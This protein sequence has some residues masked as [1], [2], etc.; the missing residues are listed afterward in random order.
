M[1]TPAPSSEPA[2]SQLISPPARTLWVMDYETIKNCFVAVFED[3]D[4]DR[5]EVFVVHRFRNDWKRFLDF[6]EACVKRKDYHLGYNNIAFDG[7]ITEHLL[8]NLKLMR[9][10][11]RAEEAA[12]F[13]SAYGSSVISRSN[14]GEFLDYPERRFKIPVIDI[15][16]LNHWDNQAKRSSLKWI[17]YA[18]DWESVEEMP[19]PYWEPVENR[20]TLDE[21]IGYCVNDV[22]ST[23]AI[24]N[25]RDRKG[26]QVMRGQIKLR[27]ALSREYGLNLHSASETRISKEIFLHYLSEKT[28]EDKRELNAVKT[29]RE[30]V[31]VKDIILPYVHFETPEFRSVLNWFSGLVVDTSD[32]DLE[33]DERKGPKFSVTFQNV[34]TDY[35]LGGL[36][37]CTRKGI[38]RSERGRIIKSADVTSFYPMLAIKNRWAPSHLPLDDFLDVYQG[39]FDK[40]KTYPKGHY[41]NYLFKIVLNATYGLSKNRYS[42]LYDPEFTFRITVNGQLLLSMLYEMLATRIPGAEP[43]M[44]NTD[45]LEFM[46]DADQEDLFHAICAEWEERTRL[47]LEYVTYERMII[48]DV[49]NYIA[50]WNE[51]GKQ[52]TKC[53]GRFE[54]EDLPLHKNKSFLVVPKALYAYFVDGVPPETYLAANQCFFDYCAGAKLRGDWFFE[55]R[56]LEED[57]VVSL[58]H[59]KLLRYYNSSKGGKLFKCNPDGREMM[60]EA[61]DTRQVIA[62]RFQ[63]RP[64]AEYNID[65]AYYLAAIRKEIKAI[66]SAPLPRYSKT[67]DV[68]QLSFAF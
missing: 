40:R 39:F 36:H 56:L 26:D 1:T 25:Y 13:L 62:N 5:R 44:Q 55:E 68:A 12:E 45:G 28:G 24:F 49:N 42:F 58:R 18:M 54:F 3:L 27:A 15:F 67:K 43:L 17:Q 51:G 20:R 34:K 29:L 16:K 14:R 38:Y 47:S 65:K 63:A 35:G 2:R 60:L 22:R 37:G 23:K 41:L 46:I 33:K 64:F 21:V 57:K 48:A 52:K 11:T 4:S 8:A 6:L 19:H 61:G 53:K 66:E 7:Q 31:V 30:Q 9:K 50:I 59:K 10:I 32:L